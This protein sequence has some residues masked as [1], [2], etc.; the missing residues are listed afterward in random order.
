M[1]ACACTWTHT[2]TPAYT[3]SHCNKVNV[4][5][6]QVNKVEESECGRENGV[7]VHWLIISQRRQDDKARQI[8]ARDGGVKDCGCQRDR[9]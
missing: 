4:W 9:V 6:A 5:P 3:N 8:K 1:Q 7:S 2:H